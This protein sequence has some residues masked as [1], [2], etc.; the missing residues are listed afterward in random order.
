M[1]FFDEFNQLS[2]EEFLKRLPLDEAKDGKS[3]ICPCGHGKNGDG[4]KQGV[5]HGRLS[6]HCHGTCGRHWSNFDLACA[7]LGYDSGTDKASAVKELKELFG[8]DGDEKSARSVVKSSRSVDKMDNKKAAN[9]TTPRNFAGLYKYCREH[10]SLRKFVDEQG[11]TWRGLTYETLDEAGALVHPQYT[12][13]DDNTCPAVILPYDDGLYFWRSTVGKERGVPKGTERKIYWASPITLDMPNFMVEGELDA[14][15][16]KQALKGLGMG[17]IATGSAQFVRKTVDELNRTYGNSERKPAFIVMFDNDEAGH[18]NG[19]KMVNALRAAGYPAVTFFLEGEMAGTQFKNS[20]TGE[21]TTVPKCDANDVLRRGNGELARRLLDA[22]EDTD[23]KLSA[24]AATLV[25]TKERERLAAESKSGI[26]D[27]PVAEYFAT[28]FFDDV[29]LMTQYSDRYT[30]FANLDGT[31]AFERDGR[32]QLFMP[33]LYLLGALPGAGKT[34]WVW[35]LVNRLAELGESCIFCSYEMSRLELYTKS[36]ARRLFEMKRAGRDVMALSAADIRRGAGNGITEVNQ[37]VAEFAETTAK[38]R[39]LEVSNANVIGLIEHLKP[40]VAAADKPPVVAVDYLQIIP[41][42]NSKANAK[43]KIDDV[44]LRL[45]DFQ[46][47]TNSTLVVVSAFNRDSGKDAT[48]Q[49]F[50]ESS[51]IEYSADVL[52]ALQLEGNDDD[53]KKSPRP[54]KFKCLKNRNGAPYDVYFNYFAAHDCFRAC[55]K[56]DLGEDD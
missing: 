46:R 13:G 5:Y 40:L 9:E 30:G 34:S 26:R 44:M 25:T 42:T 7:V 29:A 28:Q 6:W 27:F 32:K 51:A 1:N 17:V 22:I 38:L 35:Q 36:I 8:M 16:V 47:E 45:K 37:V 48:M 14:L 3:Y 10:Y 33:G 49:S 20:A 19:L 31:G 24:Q 54:M 18:G 11:G 41:P 12:Y 55:T 4:I 21:V 15:S 52:W 43:E 23:E 50:R 39:V 53:L 56:Q 2:A